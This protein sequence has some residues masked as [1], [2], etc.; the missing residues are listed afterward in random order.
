MSADRWTSMRRLPRTR[1]TCNGLTAIAVVGCR[2]GGWWTAASIYFVD[3]FAS[4]IIRRQPD[5]KLHRR[6]ADIAP[7]AAIQARLGTALWPMLAR[8]GKLLYATC[9]ILRAENEATISGFLDRHEDA[10]ALPLHERLG[11]AAGVGRQNLPGNKG[12]DGF[13]YALLEKAR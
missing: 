9:S 10:R 7:L 13:Y 4:G 11:R 6:A 12:M 5:I 1:E 3:A 8:G 2:A